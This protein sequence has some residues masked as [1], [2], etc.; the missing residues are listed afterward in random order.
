[1]SAPAI[2]QE[3]SAAEHAL[4]SGEAAKLLEEEAVLEG[5]EL[6]EP[7]QPKITT[8]SNPVELVPLLIKDLDTLSS[9]APEIKLEGVR[10]VTRYIQALLQSWTPAHKHPHFKTV[11]SKW[12]DLLCTYRVTQKMPPSNASSPSTTQYSLMSDDEITDWWVL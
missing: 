6:L 12:V 3:L 1:M 11:I 2:E 9:S 4:T 10:T 5:G 8:P 7:L